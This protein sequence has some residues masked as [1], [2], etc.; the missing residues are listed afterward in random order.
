M[1]TKHILITFLKNK[2]DELGMTQ[3]EFAEFLSIPFNTYRAYEYGQNNIKPEAM[4]HICEKLNIEP[5]EMFISPEA[6]EPTRPTIPI[7]EI[8]NL[9]SSID[10]I[11]EALSLA[12]ENTEDIKYI[13][14]LDRIFLESPTYQSAYSRLSS[15]EY[16]DWLKSFKQITGD[17][18]LF[19]TAFFYSRF[20]YSRKDEV[21]KGSPFTD[22]PAWFKERLPNYMEIILPKQNRNDDSGRG[23]A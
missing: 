20:H 10:K 13:K 12:G 5:Y 15:E 7:S 23:I 6:L 9:K 16:D 2:R 11:S 4:D 3:P 8:N 22:P 17:Y 1:G 18:G 21:S 14:R 19:R